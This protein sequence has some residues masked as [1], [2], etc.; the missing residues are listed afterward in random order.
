MIMI[1]VFIFIYRDDDI[2]PMLDFPPGLPQEEKV[3]IV[4]KKWRNMQKIALDS[5]EAT[6]LVKR[7]VQEKGTIY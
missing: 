4:P 6:N 7:L 5:S 1:L 3:K 2:H